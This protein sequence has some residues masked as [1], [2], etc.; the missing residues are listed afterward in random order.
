MKKI[1][2]P[3]LLLSVVLCAKT[4][5]STTAANAPLNKDRWLEVD[6]YWFNKNDM[7]ASSETFWNRMSPLF[8]DVAGEKGII[9]N[10]GWLMDFVLEWNGSLDAPIP[11]PQ[12]M[13]IWEM[14]TDEGYLLGNTEQRMAQAEK[15]FSAARKRETVRY[16][17]WTY[18]DLKNFI[19]IFRQTAAAHGLKDI[20]IG[21][22][23]LGWKSI[24]HGNDSKFAAK[25]PDAFS[26][27]N[28]RY[29]KAFNPTCILSND[30]TRYGAYP[31]GV[32][33]GLPI[34]KFFGDQWGDLSK[35]TGLDAIVLRDSAIGQGIYQR[36][37]P[38]GKT[39]PADPAAVKKWC[40]ATASLVRYT[41]QA[42]PKAL[43][44]G[45]SNGAAAVGDWRVNC[46][47]LESIAKE[48]FLDAY[49]D[50]SWAGAWN[51]AGQRPGRF[52]NSPHMGWTYQLAYILLHGAILSETPAKQYI[53]TETFDAWES[54]N[55]IGCARERLR[56]GIW[57]YSHAAV[58][59][60]AGLKFP[61][62]SYISWANQV[63]RLLSEDEVD[64]L[65][66]ETNRAFR[67]LD[68]IRDINGPTLVYTRSAM[69]WQNA[70]QPAVWMKEWLDDQAGSMMKFGAPILS[71]AR[72]E[73][74]GRA[75][76]D[77]DMFIIQTPVHLKPDEKASLEK[78]IASGK[79]VML[80]GS[81]ANGID[82]DFLRLAGLSSPDKS[83]GPEKT[84]G[85]VA[86]INH[87][88]AKNCPA[89][90]PLYHPYTKNILDK[91]SG[92]QAGVV[93]T[94]SNSP[95]L[96]RKGNL[97]VWDPPELLIYT[98]EPRPQGSLPSDVLLG[99]AV[100]YA[101][102]AR[103]VNDDLSKAGKFSARSPGMLLP[104]WCG[105]WTK[106]SGE[107][108]VLLGDIEEGFEHTGKEQ[109][110]V[111][112]TLP[113]PYGNRALMREKWAAGTYVIP[114][115]T[116]R[117]SLKRGESR[118]LEIKELKDNN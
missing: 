96:L 21:T 16:E 26:D 99:S 57:A 104:V 29:N 36:S 48:G 46:F 86:N 95:A 89:T 7:K 3:L 92:S 56:W 60:P 111:E 80:C 101:L 82:R 23:V 90:F 41:K 73:N 71:A 6:L 88:L 38:A 65:A 27:V 67:D 64:F 11:F 113:P 44:I 50:Q 106:K 91:N 81:P 10:I 47:D 14:F 100:P 22:F 83:P 115:N 84:M 34:T 58:K 114:D 43:V 93:Y 109:S 59:T 116:I 74:L 42:N 1:F 40:D 52:W 28:Q 69:E 112:I 102:A 72:I 53:L 62:G 49:I 37:G 30:K 32:P 66:T 19:A 2:L 45:Y 24:Y 78:L 18:N 55:V 5:A 105:S 118:L 70:N 85:I 97:S 25:H 35:K 39:A 108:A 98:N 94:V 20:R 8:T 61:A 79:P 33:D 76:V 75:G 51:E 110:R 17:N 4:N 63:K 31:D 13:T 12:G 68:N 15:R 87:P 77:S 9:L 117:Y 103:L 107:L 54:W